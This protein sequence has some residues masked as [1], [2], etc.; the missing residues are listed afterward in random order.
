VKFSKSY[1]HRL[2]ANIPN[3]EREDSES[4]QLTSFSGLIVLQKLFKEIGLRDLLRDGMDDSRKI[5]YPLSWV[6]LWLIVHFWLGYK[7]LRDIYFYRDDPMVERVLTVNRLPDVSTISRRLKDVDDMAVESVRDVNRS[8]VLDRIFVEGLRRITLDFDGVVQSTKRHAEGSAVGY[9]K[10]ARG[11]RSYYPLFCTLSQTGQ[12]L[13][14]HHRSGNVHDSNGAEEFVKSCLFKAREAAPQVAVETRMDGAFFQEPLMDTLNAQNVEFT[15]SVPFSR[16]PELKQ[17]VESRKRW[18]S[19]KEFGYFEADW[20]PGSWAQGYRLICVRT[21]QMEQRKGPLQLD[22]FEPYDWD[23][24]YQVIMT[25]K[26]QSAKKVIEYH[27]GRGSQEKIF[28][29]AKSQM[30]MGHIPVKTLNGNK[31]YCI[32]SI[33]AHNLN[34]E[35]QMNSKERDRGTTEKR[36]SLW[37]FEGIASLRRRL[38]QRAG[39]FIRPQNK[40]TLVIGAN[41]KIYDEIEALAA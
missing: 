37:S 23:Y 26:T 12:F 16:F 38:I 3:I 6:S 35:L 13:D 39:R 15:V 22:F 36:A 18:S 5:S 14:L 24:Q 10:Q 32:A 40:L 41:Q 34:H 21:E 20:S 28:A 1:I 19:K 8:I 31:L 9:N 29:Q 33:L 11:R 30:N 2:S 17:M 7:R 25:N 4:R 27:R